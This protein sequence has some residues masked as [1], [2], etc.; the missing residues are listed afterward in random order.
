MLEIVIN[1][2][3]GGALIDDYNRY[4]KLRNASFFK[5][6]LR[7]PEFR[8]QLLYRVRAHSRTMSILLKPL[9]LFNSHN[10][11]FGCDDIG[12]GLF[13]EHGFSTIIACKHLGRNCWINQQVTIGFSSEG[14][15]PYIGDNV[16]I[17]AGA[18]VIG[19]ITI[20]DD[21]IIG[22]NAVVVKDVP[23]HCIV[24]GVPAKIIKRRTTLNGEWVRC[25]N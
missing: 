12:G 4:K 19:E 9:L 15:S 2:F 20:G 23:S 22:A 8:A 14:H 11:Y 1:V 13:I 16:Q 10:L 18:K 7:Y 6:L 5:L 3:G 17:K 21:V 25:E 24:V